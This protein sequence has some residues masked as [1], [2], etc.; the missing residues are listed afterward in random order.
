MLLRKGI[1]SPLSRHGAPR[2]LGTQLTLCPR[3]S[4]RRA[5]PRQLWLV[6]LSRNR[7]TKASGNPLD[8]LPVRIRT[9]PPPM[10]RKATPRSTPEAICVSLR[11]SLL[12]APMRG[13]RPR[14]PS[15]G[16]RDEIQ[17]GESDV[18]SPHLLRQRSERVIPSPSGGP[19]GPKASPGKRLVRTAG[20][21]GGGS[22]RTLC[23]S[24]VIRSS[25]PKMKSLIPWTEMPR[26]LATG[27]QAT[28]WASTDAKKRR[29][30]TTAS[31]ST[32]SASVRGSLTGT[33][34]RRACR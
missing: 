20:G 19:Q 33:R 16:T 27:L 10:D 3:T 2:R 23:G 32:G 6:A 25:P 4:S 31:A 22:S 12:V 14:P 15:S 5:N 34:R 26:L 1:Q 18:D 30:A 8:R 17:N 9:S 29:L 11:R 28:S 13:G 24:S 7:P 21:V